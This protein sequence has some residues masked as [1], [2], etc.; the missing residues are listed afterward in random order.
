MRPRSS[1]RAEKDGPESVVFREAVVP[2]VGRVRRDLRDEQRA[3]RPRK[4]R[5]HHVRVPARLRGPGSAR[6]GARSPGG[7]DSRGMRP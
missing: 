4:A 5:Q 1:R 3:R 6:D 2:E 7:S